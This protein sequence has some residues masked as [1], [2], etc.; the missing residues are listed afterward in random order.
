[1]RALAPAPATAL[2]VMARRERGGSERA[3]MNLLDE[4]FGLL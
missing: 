4:N 1:M 3:E 2:S